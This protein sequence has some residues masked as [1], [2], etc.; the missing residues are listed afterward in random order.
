MQNSHLKNSLIAAGIAVFAGVVTLG[1]NV[2]FGVTNP[3]QSPATAG[4]ISP[5]FSGLDVKGKIN[6]SNPAV[7]DGDVVI[8]DN[9]KINGAVNV[10]TDAVNAMQLV[11]N[12][13]VIGGFM[14]TTGAITAGGLILSPDNNMGIESSGPG[15]VKINDPLD[16]WE[17]IINTNKNNV[18]AEMPVKIADDL[19]VTGSITNSTT[20][21][22]GYVRV[23][24]DLSV[25]GDLIVYNKDLVMTGMNSKIR[26]SGSQTIEI[27]NNVR[28][29][30]NL[31]LSTGK[32]LFNNV[33]Q[34]V[35]IG[36]AADNAYADLNVA[37]KI[38]TTGAVING[39]ANSPTFTVT[40]GNTSLGGKL[41]VAGKITAAGGDIAANDYSKAGLTI[42]TTNGPTMAFD[43]DD[44]NTFGGGLYLNYY[45]GQPV[46][47]GASGKNANLTVYGK[48]TATSGFGTYTSVAASP[49]TTIL[50]GGY[51][52]SSASC[53]SLQLISCG[54]TN[55]DSFVSI[56]QINPWGSTCTVSA[57]NNSPN[58][59][60]SLTAKAICL[61][62]KN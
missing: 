26:S 56:S 58:L 25:D 4:L 20:N 57:K 53:G 22:L 38:T 61:D 9:V 17:T 43:H 14:K 49:I 8:D 10:P 47:V 31:D 13:G 5:T 7:N 23:N 44:I 6:N 30:G 28:L 41:N 27:G 16:A 32:Y 12:D 11:A 37:G 45:T 15:G 24:D 40:T 35:K 1:A 60:S 21:N 51:Q 34:I 55:T 2:A 33:D 50:P 54:N 18:G 3:A 42:G 19:D 46:Y 62:T 52:T 36:S 48:V 39:F 59:S 29:N